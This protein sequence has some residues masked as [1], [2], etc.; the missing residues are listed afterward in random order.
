LEVCPRPQGRKGILFLLALSL[1]YP[2]YLTLAPWHM[3]RYLTPILPL[4][5]ILLGVA[6]FSVIERNRLAGLI[7]LG[8]LI[9]SDAIH[10]IPLHLIELAERERIEKDIAAGV[11][12][13]KD[14]LTTVRGTMSSA[15]E[16][17][18]LGR[19]TSP[20]TSYFYEI[21]HTPHDP[22][23]VVCNYLNEH[24][25]SSDLVLATYDDLPIQLYTGLQ[26][27]GNLQGQ[28]IPPDP[29][30]IVPRQNRDGG[31]IGGRDGALLQPVQ[32]ILRKKQFA[33][34]YR[35]EIDFFLGNCPEPGVHRFK[36]P[37]EGPPILILRKKNSLKSD[38]T[39]SEKR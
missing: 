8:I 15:G 11:I 39:Q 2:A 35:R 4:V 3:F 34:H 9:L 30:W 38:I 10:I 12:D 21:T 28:P 7:L 25:K 24:A 16:V 31:W 27:V 33:L 23:P 13:A 29:D 5:S 1:L 37:A 14:A 22:E 6:V 20:L 32:E 26:V 36:P 19:V 18:S 17:F